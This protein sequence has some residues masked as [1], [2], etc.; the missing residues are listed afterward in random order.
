MNNKK[1]RKKEI[2]E[3]IQ[4]ITRY[5]PAATPQ[6]LRLRCLG[7]EGRRVL[8]EPLNRIYASQADQINIYNVNTLERRI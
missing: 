5:L 2:I 8:Q 7:R 6:Q 1:K 3:S 4:F